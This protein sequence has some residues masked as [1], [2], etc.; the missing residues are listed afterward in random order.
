LPE[1]LKKS[2]LLPIYRPR[3]QPSGNSGGNIC[4]S[5][6]NAARRRRY[7]RHAKLA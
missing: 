4:R 2:R 6:Q 7:H 3:H 1:T 5:M